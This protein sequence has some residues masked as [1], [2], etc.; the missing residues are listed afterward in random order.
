MS[1]IINTYC[2]VPQERLEALQN[3]VKKK[4]LPP[5]PEP[6]EPS[7]EPTPEPESPLEKEEE[8]EEDMP[9]K[10]SPPP[11]P[12]TKEA[13]GT[14]LSEETKTMVKEKKLPNKVMHKFLEAIQKY[15]QAEIPGGENLNALVSLALSQ[16]RKVLPNEAKFFGF[17]LDKGLFHF[18]KNRHKI[19]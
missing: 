14:T 2:I 5:P 10:P 12:P 18:V 7:R 17:L 16:S 15:D 4:T 1:D 6:K 9:R 11:E 13:E 19:K 8:M 3:E